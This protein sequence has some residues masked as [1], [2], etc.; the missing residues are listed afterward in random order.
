MKKEKA[1]EKEKKRG[2][3][4]RAGT[5]EGVL[6]HG[7]YDMNILFPVLFLVGRWEK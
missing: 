6:S 3:G 2:K 7:G 5:P 1:E 4:K